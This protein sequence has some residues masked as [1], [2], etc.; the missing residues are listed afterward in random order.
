MK[1]EPLNTMHDMDPAALIE[2]WR[3]AYKWANGREACTPV[4]KNGWFV[5]SEFVRRRKADLCEMIVA[6]E[7]RPKA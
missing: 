2:R 1:P 6:L 4:Y 5:F 7:N 3:E